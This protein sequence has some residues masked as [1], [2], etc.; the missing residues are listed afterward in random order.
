MNEQ[1]QHGF[2]PSPIEGIIAVISGGLALTVLFLLPLLE[3]AD[4]GIPGGTF[5]AGGENFWVVAVVLACQSAAL[6]WAKSAPRTVLTLVV[7]LPVVL[8]VFVPGPAFSLS[9]IA[10]FCA[11]FLSAGRLPLPRVAPLLVLAVL[12]IAGAQAF[13]DFRTGLPATAAVTSAVGQALVVVGAPLL[14][15]LVL[16]ARREARLSR[17]HEI[18]ALAR[19]QQARIE[20]AVS[21]ERTAMSRELHDI[22]AHHMSGIALM[23]AAIQQQIDTDPEEAKRSAQQVRSQSTAVLEDLRRIVGLLREHPEGTR[24]VETIAGI[25]GLVEER[26]RTGMDVDLLLSAARPDR[27]LAAGIGPLAQLV[28]YRMVQESLSN[29][30]AHSPGARCVVDVDDSDPSQLIAVVHHGHAP[31]GQVGEGA[32]AGAGVGGGFGWL[33]LRERAELI[34]AALDHGPNAE[35]GWS[36]RLVVPREVA[37]HPIDADETPQEMP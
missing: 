9:T 3:E 15:A 19:E 5:P 1:A 10:I 8:A 13:N 20:A 26:R 34:G 32:A 18:Q 22:A 21:K 33:G 36:V 7:L 6:L 25:P 27:E 16:S 2:R 28:V 31:A 4:T 11:V 14:F 23:T 35:G 30:A 37:R 12:I 29:A 17:T 24:S